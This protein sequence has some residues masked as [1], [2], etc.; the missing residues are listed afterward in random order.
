MEKKVSLVLEGGGFRG[1]YTA[2]CLSWLI[3]EGIKFDY[4]YGISTGAVHLCSFLIE[5]KHYLYDLST[6]YIADK[7]LVG[8]R[9]LLR[10]KRYVGYDYLFSHILPEVFHY[11]IDRVLKTTC[12]AKIGVY[13][14][15][16]GETEYVKVQDIDHDMQLLKGACTLPIIGRIVNYKNHHL[17]DGGITKMIPIEESVKDGCDIHIVITTKPADFV[18]KPAP[19][20]I[21]TLMKLNY[22]KYPSVAKDYAVRHLNYQK[23]IDLVKSLQ[24]E[25]K[26]LLLYPSR[27]IPVKRLTG[28]KEN[29][30]KLYALGRQDMEIRKEEIFKLLGICKV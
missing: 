14:L 29:L 28:D 17:L 20:L 15:D 9:S 1:A 21:K 8:W 22:R 5:E 4:A 30:L 12:Q 23:Q 11:D 18:R 7:Q 27:N 24:A 6:N 26:A 13:N 3:D 10:E 25:N 2:G 19:F 16:K